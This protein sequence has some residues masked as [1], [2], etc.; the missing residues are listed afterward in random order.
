MIRQDQRDHLKSVMDWTM[1]NHQWIG[2]IQQR[3]EADIYLYESDLDRDFR[4][5]IK[6]EMDCSSYVMMLFHFCGFKDPSGNGYNGYGDSG[7][8]YTHLSHFSDPLATL[9]GSIVVFG[10]NGADHAAIV[11]EGGISDPIVDSHGTDAGPGQ[12][13]MSRLSPSFSEYTYLSIGSQ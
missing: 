12:I 13:A 1:A 5:G 6:Q 8:F 7:E 3:P 2:Y 9:T 10:P 4:K 11:Y